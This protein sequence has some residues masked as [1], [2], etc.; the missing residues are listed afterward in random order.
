MIPIVIGA[1]GTVPKGLEK[2]TER[3][4]N[5]RTSRNHSNYS[6]VEIGQNMEESPGDLRRLAVNQSPVKDHQLTLVRKP[7]KK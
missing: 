7:H 4:G 3:V 1:L 6:I 5:R 2:G